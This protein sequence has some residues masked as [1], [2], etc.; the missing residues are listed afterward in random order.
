MQEAVIVQGVA[1][2]FHRFHANRPRTLQEAIVRGLRRMRTVEQFWALQDVSFTVATG[3]MVGLIGHNGAGKSTLLRLIGGIGKPNQGAVEVHGRI[4]AL[5]SLGAGF[6]PDL[7]GRENVF[8]NGV[9]SGLTLSEVNQKFDSIVAFAE[10]EQFID[11]PL[12]TYSS[13][14]RMRLGFAIATHIEPEILLIDEVLAVGDITFQNKCMAR[15]K[16]F[17]EIGCTVL[18]VSHNLWFIRENCDAALWLHMGQVKAYEQAETVV[19]QYLEIMGPEANQPA[20]SQ[21]P[22]VLTPAAAEA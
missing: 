16:Q 2:K 11:S 17:K 14:M 10:L 20:D 19:S 18:I 3:Q 15:I 6:H 21:Q 13:G 9:I 7:T 1:K 22:P 12:H 5:L 4:G 8:V